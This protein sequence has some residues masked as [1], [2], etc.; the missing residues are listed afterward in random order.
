MTKLIAHKSSDR[1][2]TVLAGNLEELIIR[3]PGRSLRS[4]PGGVGQGGLAS[5]LSQL[6]PFGLFFVWFF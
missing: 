3:Y 2:R 6:Q 1:K 5:Q 4:L